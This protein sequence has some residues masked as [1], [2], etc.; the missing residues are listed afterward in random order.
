M[1][2]RFE[3]HD[4]IIA[5][6]ARRSGGPGW[7]NQPVWVVVRSRNDGSYRE[8]CLQPDDLTA[9]IWALY[10]ISE[11]AHKAMTGAVKILVEKARMMVGPGSAKQST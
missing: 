7:S 11:A 4:E 5:A 8:E 3:E 2:A 6:Y 9:E 1:T 10:D